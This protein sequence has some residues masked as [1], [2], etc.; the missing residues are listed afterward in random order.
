MPA[1][2][3]SSTIF[4]EETSA[5]WNGSSANHTEEKVPHFNFGDFN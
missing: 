5:S 1:I 3:T 2:D 4:T